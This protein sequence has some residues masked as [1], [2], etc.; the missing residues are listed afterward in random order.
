MNK[1]NKETNREMKDMHCI[2]NVKDGDMLLFQ[3]M[4]RRVEQMKEQ[5]KETHQ[6]ERKLLSQSPIN[7]SK[8]LK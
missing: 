6:L 3:I 2:Q 4:E 1:M 5:R 8:T 7:W